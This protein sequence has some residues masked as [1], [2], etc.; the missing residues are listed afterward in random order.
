MKKLFA[1]LLALS[2][3]LSALPAV[4]EQQYYALNSNGYVYKYDMSSPKQEMTT[5]DLLLDSGSRQSD[6]AGREW[7]QV[8]IYGTNEYG[9][10]PVESVRLLSQEEVNAILNPPA[11]ATPTAPQAAT[12]APKAQQTLP[13]RSTNYCL[14]RASGLL[15]QYDL[16]N[17]KE[18]LSTNQ[19][20]VF[21][22]QT[23]WDANG[24][25]WIQVQI[26]NTNRYGWVK[27]DSVWFLTQEQAN[28]Y[29]DPTQPTPTASPTAA[30]TSTPKPG[31]TPI[32]VLS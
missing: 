12:A 24:S 13:P 14:M 29:L 6:T 4:A 32:P 17:G 28:P 18:T 10:V 26:Y 22:G 16:V 8:Q 7:M 20:L 1:A 23:N 27:V 5:S 31:G 3:F 2:L 21:N 9:W 15:Y 30:P 25:L 19:L 11:A